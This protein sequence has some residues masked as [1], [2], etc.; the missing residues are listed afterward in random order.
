[1]IESIKK[2]R[3]LAAVIS[4][5][6]VA[7][8][9]T[10]CG[11]DPTE[12]YTAEV[13][14]IA[15]ISES[16]TGTIKVG[17][18]MDFASTDETLSFE[19]LMSYSDDADYDVNIGLTAA[20][21]GDDSSIA[22]YLADQD[23][24]AV[25]GNTEKVYIDLTKIGDMLNSAGS[26]GDESSADATSMITQMFGD[27]FTVIEFDTSELNDLVNSSTSGDTTVDT[28]ALKGDF[29]NTFTDEDFIN[30]LKGL[31]DKAVK[32]KNSIEIR[33]ISADDITEIGDAL[34][35]SA[36]KHD[37]DAV[38]KLFDNLNDSSN[39]ESSSDAD[40]D[41]DSTVNY[42]IEYDPDKLVQKHTLE[43]ENTDGDKLTLV[44]EINDTDS[45]FKDL[46]G[47]ARTFKDI[48]GYTLKEFSESLTNMFAPGSSSTDNTD[49]YID[50]EYDFDID[51]Y[52]DTDDFNDDYLIPDDFSGST[53]SDSDY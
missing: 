35:T 37:L 29:V 30:A 44:F 12:Q 9:F 51:D 5:G 19:N 31:G 33:D 24:L 21:S 11:A 43:V 16:E 36:E 26:D 15:S 4:L 25:S 42:K 38:S 39:D 41:K 34:K 40:N 17:L 1:M 32:V 48:T 49:S 45:G 28:G 10:G 27:L 53:D 50:S 52:A 6:V 14:K 3:T 46:S 8:M 20:W 23:L 18:D 47:D 2:S 22:I 7:S 13:E